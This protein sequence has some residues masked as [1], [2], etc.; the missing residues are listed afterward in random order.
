MT[1]LFC[2]SFDHYTTAQLSRKWTL[3]EG[4]WEIDNDAGR[5]GGGA[6]VGSYH[7]Y[8]VAKGIPGTDV[9]YVGFAYKTSKLTDSG[10]FV[11]FYEGA[12][13]HVTVRVTSTGAIKVESNYATVGQTAGGV[14]AVNTWNYIE[15]GVRIDNTVGW[16]RVRVDGADVLQATGS[17]GALDTRE[18]GTG[19]I[20]S[21]NLGAHS[22]F[23]GYTY[24]D[25]LY[26]CDDAGS[27]N[28]TFLGDV[29]I[30][31]QIGRAHV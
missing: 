22:A 12:T 3:A 15:I 26:I 31:C 14:I 24:F 8:H 2:D 11:K 19:L 9:V 6:L 28:N 1:L 27:R 25:D 17:P 13:G 20:D 23:D 29:R 10:H 21:I 30:D 18:G 16:V 4:Y 5:R 7:N